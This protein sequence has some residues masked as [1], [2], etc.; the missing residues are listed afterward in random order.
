M[1]APILITGAGQRAGL[2]LAKSF[3]A[4][5]QPVIFSYRSHK[6]GVTELINLGAQAIPADFSSTEQILEFIQQV[7][8]LTP[9]L[10]A[11]I[12]NA[13]SWSPDP[14]TATEAAAVFQHLFMVHQQAPYLINLEL[15]PLLIQQAQASQQ[16]TDIIHLSDDSVRR[17]SAKHGA[18]LA[19]KAALEN[20]SL[21]FAQRLAPHVKVNSIAPALLAFNT[22]D[23][24]EYQAQALAK[25][26]LEVVP[27]FG[28]LIQT[29]NFLLTQ[30]YLTGACLPLNGG[31]H[32]KG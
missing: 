4:Q 22:Q 6:A 9:K 26:A 5:G 28:V 24:P 11:I 31:R 3:L 29:V 21:S 32:L 20:L 2:A 13:S 7:Q 17:G 1:P 15:A 23:T 10:R 16:A 27:G 19:S 8:D 30:N 12:H 14:K 18:Y 25:S